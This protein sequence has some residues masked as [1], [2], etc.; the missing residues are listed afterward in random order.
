[1]DKFHGRDCFNNIC[2]IFVPVVMKGNLSAIVFINTR[3]GND[4]TAKITS[5]IFGNNIW[6]IF[7]WFCINVKSLFMFRIAFCFYFFERWTKNS[8]HF[9][10]QSSAECV[11]EKGII[12]MMHTFPKTIMAITALSDEAVDMRQWI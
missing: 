8:L 3:S 7:V 9:I 12:K 1:M 6:I 2:I 11:T 4:R 5:N 10:E